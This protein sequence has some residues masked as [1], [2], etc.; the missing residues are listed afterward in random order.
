MR[1]DS[2]DELV[3]LY[4]SQGENLGRVPLRWCD[5]NGSEASVSVLKNCDHRNCL[6]GN[7]V[8]RA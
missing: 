5:R 8:R 7:Q 4:D 2:R 1:Y 3:S 6:K